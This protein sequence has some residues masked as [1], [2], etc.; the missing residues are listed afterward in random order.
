MNKIKTKSL[1]F[2]CIN[3]EAVFRRNRK[4]PTIMLFHT[5]H[6]SHHWLTAHE[7]CERQSSLRDGIFSGLPVSVKTSG[8]A[9]ARES[10]LETHKYTQLMMPVMRVDDERERA[11]V[12]GP[13]K[14]NQAFINWK[15]VFPVHYWIHPRHEIATI[16]TCQVRPSERSI[17]TGYIILWMTK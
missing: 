9:A 13:Y 5:N 2:V 10:E 12:H 1:P 11:C 8:W 6:Y 4:P 17:G 15:T 14:R 7:H 3:R 16:L